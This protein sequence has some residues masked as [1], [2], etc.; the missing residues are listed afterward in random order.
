MKIIHQ[1]YLYDLHKS[2]VIG[3]IDNELDREKPG[4]KFKALLKT[5]EGRYF[6]VIIKNKFI[7]DNDSNPVPGKYRPVNRMKPISEKKA[8]KWA[9]KNLSVE[10]YIAEFIAKQSMND[11]VML[12]SKDQNPLTNS[13]Q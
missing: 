13:L 5:D 10:K 8:K 7:F 12:L 1:G 4:F 11:S 6:L 2:T 9:L 3:E